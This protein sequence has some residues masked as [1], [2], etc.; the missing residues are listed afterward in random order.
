MPNTRE[1]MIELAEVIDS[2]FG[3]DAAYFDVDKFKVFNEHYGYKIGNQLLGYISSVLK[4]ALHDNEIFSRLNGDYFVILMHY[5]NEDELILRLKEIKNDI[6]DYKNKSDYRYDIAVRMGICKIDSK[7]IEIICSE[8]SQSVN[9]ISHVNQFIDKASLARQS[10]KSMPLEMFYTFYQERMIERI[11]HEKEI[12]SEM[13]EALNHGDFVFY[14][15]QQ[16]V[17]T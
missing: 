6:E 1:K 3:C 17:K 4:H 11:L 13:Y 14:L 2:Y 12:E 10:I 7:S 5:Q 8:K 16:S 9:I 15:Q